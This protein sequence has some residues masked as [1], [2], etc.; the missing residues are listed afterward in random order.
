MHYSLH[1]CDPFRTVGMQM[2]CGQNI[3][4]VVQIRREMQ[5]MRI[6]LRMEYD[7]AGKKIYSEKDNFVYSVAMPCWLTHLISDT[8]QDLFSP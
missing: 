6:I 3:L 4:E 8:F 7:I 2:V 1:S 5:T